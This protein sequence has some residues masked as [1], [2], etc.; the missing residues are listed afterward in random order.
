MLASSSPSSIYRIE[1]R[2]HERV[3]RKIAFR[4][5]KSRGRRKE[6]DKLTEKSLCEELGVSRTVVR[7]AIKVLAA[8]GLIEVKPK[9]G[10]HVCPRES[11]SLADPQLLG[12]MCEIRPD[13]QLLRILCE[14]REIL[15]PAAAELAAKRASPQE[16]TVIN[17]Y[18]GR[19]EQAT[20]RTRRFIE[21]D[22][23]FHGAIFRACH[24]ELLAHTC[25]IVGRAFRAG[26]S[27]TVKA[28]ASLEPAVQMHHA[29]AEAI[30]NRDSR[31]ARSAM[32]DLLAKTRKDIHEHLHVDGIFGCTGN[33]ER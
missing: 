15:E 22:T 7:E 33:E 13:G 8:K 29:V 16:L 20:R 12:W 30:A 5:M 24:N 23:E 11:W 18:F 31:T 4:I 21:A 27:A 14:V 3:L 10:I 25:S 2:L 26:L 28:L 1:D 19:M 32:E 6:C 17:R 9:T